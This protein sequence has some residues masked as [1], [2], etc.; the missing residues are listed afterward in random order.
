MTERFRNM[1]LSLGFLIFLMGADHV[2]AQEQRSGP[3]KPEAQINAIARLEYMIGDWA[4]EGWMDIGGRRA[5]FRGG[6]VVQ[7][8]LGGI[9]LLVEGSFFAKILGQ[10]AEVPVHTTL[11]VISFN[12]ETKKYGFTTWL[13]TGASGERELNLT[14]DGWQWETKGS[15]GVVRYTM[16]L[17]ES[18]D[19]HEIGE[20]SSDGRTW[21]KFFEMT[22]RK[23]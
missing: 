5:S 18:G 3:P 14:A 6:E 23:K 1:F 19:W 10:D 7:K 20:R 4:G 12:P 16:K 2:T 13:A 21:Q 8:K 11:G 15:R 22:L 17:T 9:A